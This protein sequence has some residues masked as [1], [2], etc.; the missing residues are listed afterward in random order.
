M[1][2]NDCTGLVKVNENEAKDYL[3]KLVKETRPSWATASRL[4]WLL[5]MA[6]VH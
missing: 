2:K 5:F 4:S 3:D 6:V 1:A